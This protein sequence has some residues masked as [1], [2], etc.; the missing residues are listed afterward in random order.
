MNMRFGENDA[1]FI[2]TSGTKKLNSK[3]N[4]LPSYFGGE[5]GRG[6]E[7]CEKS[8]LMLEFLDQ[9]GRNLDHC[10]AP[11]IDTQSLQCI[12]P[13]S[14]PSFTPKHEEVNVEFETV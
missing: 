1:P 12:P 2:W 3:I 4:H 13:V 6:M 10:V 5:M 8:T 7:K 14:M 9:C 11:D